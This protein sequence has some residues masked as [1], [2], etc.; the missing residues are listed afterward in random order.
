[1]G[2][3]NPRYGVPADGDARLRSV[4]RSFRQAIMGKILAHSQRFARNRQYVIDC[5]IA[6]LAGAVYSHNDA[7]LNEIGR[8][9]LQVGAQY[10]RINFELL[11]QKPDRTLKGSF[12]V[13]G[14]KESGRRVVAREDLTA[15]DEQDDGTFVLPERLK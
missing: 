8:Q 9:L 14:A 10:G 4:I 15:V 2:A 12:A 7:M 6:D 11:R 5:V 3:D 13:D 1:M